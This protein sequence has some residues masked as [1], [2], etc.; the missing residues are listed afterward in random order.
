M[1]LVERPAWRPYREVHPGTRTTVVG[2]LRVL[3]RV[4]SREL[5]NRRDLLVHLPPSYGTGTRRY[6]VLYM[7]DGQN[8]F[9]AA[10]SFS[11][12]WRVDETMEE[13]ATEGL[14]AIVVGIP[15]AGAARLDEYSPWRDRRRGGGQGE[16]YLAFLV[17]TV[18]PLVDGEFRTRRERQATGVLGSSLG[19][20]IS[21]YAFFR[22][23]DVFGLVGAL[24]PALGF[25]GGAMLDFLARQP[26]VGGR[27]YLDSGTREGAFAALDRRLWGLAYSRPYLRRVRR[28][29]RLLEAEGYRRGDDLLYLEDR[30]AL[31]HE[32][33]WG[34]RLGGALR[35][36]LRGLV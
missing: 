21:L 34:R 35:F 27:V 12:E 1:A 28:A 10:T 22:H 32:A 14:E 7:Q 29:R 20:V 31:H 3:P 2:D 15:N 9:D 4:A 24:S 25:A 16:A 30:G 6:P 8:L 5:G 18:K 13:L 17:G 11:G 23:A 33:A 36:L 19:G 26:R